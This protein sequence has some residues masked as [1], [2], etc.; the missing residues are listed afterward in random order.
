MELAQA[1]PRPYTLQRAALV[2][3]AFVSV[4]PLLLYLDTLQ[5][6]RTLDQP[7]V[8]VNL[9]LSLGAIL[10]GFY[11]FWAMTG[12][13][14]EILRA[15]Q[16][17]QVAAPAGRAPVEADFHMPVFGAIL[18]IEPIRETDM[19][20]AAVEQLRAVWELEARPHL[21]RRVAIS[22]RNA[23]EPIVGTL[24]QITENGLLLLDAESQK[25]GVSYRRIS[26]IEGS[27]R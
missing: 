1:Q 4:L 20:A 25:V 16:E 22:V 24:S 7:K 21:G 26:A 6:L 5:S 14:A 18:E 8:L 15:A 12:R 3:F 23:R 13:M 9:A 2:V 19:M 27:A 17:H 11:L 10:I